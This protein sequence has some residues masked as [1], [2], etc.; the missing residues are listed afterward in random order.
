M[1]TNPVPFHRS[2]R[3]SAGTIATILLLTPGLTA[4]T[5]PAAKPPVPVTSTAAAEKVDETVVLSPF[6]VTSDNNGHQ[7]SN[8]LSGTRLNSKLED[9]GS[10]ITVVTKQQ[11]TDLGMLDINDV[12]R[13][14]AS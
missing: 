12:F 10:S 3:I 2:L 1:Q 13:Y 5:A 11:M 8:T 9:L 7:A 4:Q 14:E 6:T